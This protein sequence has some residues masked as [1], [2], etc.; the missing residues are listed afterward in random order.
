M[1]RASK[2][3]L[4]NNEGKVLLQLRDK[5]HSYPGS[6][7]LFGGHVNDSETPEEALEIHRKK[8]KNIR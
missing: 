7:A 4:V 3:I 2:I 5:G 6:W 1:E 8:Q